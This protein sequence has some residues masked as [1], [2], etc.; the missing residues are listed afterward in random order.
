MKKLSIASILFH[1]ILKRIDNKRIWKRICEKKIVACDK[2]FTIEDLDKIRDALHKAGA[3]PIRKDDTVMLDVKTWR[4][5]QKADIWATY[6]LKK[7]GEKVP[8]IL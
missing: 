4:L 1:K 8:R 2:P 3:R 5:L 6:T 7:A